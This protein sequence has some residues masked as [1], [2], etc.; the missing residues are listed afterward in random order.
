M[1]VTVDVPVRI[2]VDPGA[3]A[4]RACCIE[5]ALA[6]AVGRALKKSSD[7]VLDARGGY[8]SVQ[9]HPPDIRWSGNALGEV[10]QGVR[11]ATQELI[12]AVLARA[13]DNAA[14]T[15]K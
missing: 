8:V 11:L 9:V 6:A 5:E 12:A 7:V 13:A 1:P 4:T 14:I 2:R 15:E 3:L 10:P